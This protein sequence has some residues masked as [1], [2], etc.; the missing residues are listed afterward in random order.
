MN[1][2]ISDSFAYACFRN[3]GKLGGEQEQVFQAIKHEHS[4]A[5]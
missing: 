4:E 3:P 5:K 2:V 1:T